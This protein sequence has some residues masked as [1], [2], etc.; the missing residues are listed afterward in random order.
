MGRKCFTLLLC[1]F[2]LL[3]LAGCWNAKELDELSIASMIAIDKTD[4]TYEI[5]AQIINPAQNVEEERT[6]RAPV[7]THRVTGASVFEGLRG[8]TTD[9]PRKLYLAHIRV[10]VISEKIAKEDFAEVLDFF[11]RDHQVRTDFFVV[12]SRDQQAKEILKVLTRVEEIPAE[13]V[14]SSITFSEENWAPTK[15]MQ[16]D[17]IVEQLVLDG[18]NP[19]VT[20]IRVV[21][22]KEIGGSREHVESIETQAVLK[23][24]NLAAFREGKLVG[25]MTEDQSKGYNY[26]RGNVQST[27]GVIP[28]KDGVLTFEV[29]RSESNIEA[30]VINGKPQIDV[31]ISTEGNIAEVTCAIDLSD[32]HTIEKLEKEIADDIK[33]ISMDSIARAQ[34]DFRSDI[35]GFG[36][37]IRRDDPAYWKSVKNDWN[38]QFEDLHVNVNVDFSIHH[39]GTLTESFIYEKKK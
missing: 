34:T 39:T 29:I 33:T 21:G 15:G 12:I 14:F 36:E 32:P 1:C 6:D 24:Q 16:I 9:I 22:D 11:F 28:C 30:K 23:L 27:L 26:I 37:H 2:L 13:K 19:V 10:I 3:P 18:D 35:F 31:I 7:A 8:L 20:G 38:T 17:D 5:T 25:W 4:D